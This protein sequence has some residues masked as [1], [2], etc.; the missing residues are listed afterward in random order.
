M[1]ETRLSKFPRHYQVRRVR[2]MREAW[3]V[4][5]GLLTATVKLK[6]AAIAERFA[7]D[8][9]DLYRGHDLPGSPPEKGQRTA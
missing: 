8:V 5:N 4:D 3:T 9:R 1:I 7:D 6:R 2:L